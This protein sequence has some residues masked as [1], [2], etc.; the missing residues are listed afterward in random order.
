MD[1]RTN[2]TAGESIRRHGLD[3]LVRTLNPQVPGSNPGG[4]TNEHGALVDS[5]TKEETNDV[6]EVRVTADQVPRWLRREAGAFDPV[7]GLRESSRR[8]ASELR[9]HC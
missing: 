4:R 6:G 1:G 9:R 2:K 7:G 5:L 3:G 8:K